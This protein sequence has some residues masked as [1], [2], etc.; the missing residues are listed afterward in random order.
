MFDF[1]SNG[2]VVGWNDVL[3]FRGGIK[4][5]YKDVK[6]DLQGLQNRRELQVRNGNQLIIFLYSV[7]IQIIWIT[8]SL[9]RPFRFRQLRS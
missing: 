7:P 3:I 1:V 4:R 9:A 2:G 6:C 5:T 8:I